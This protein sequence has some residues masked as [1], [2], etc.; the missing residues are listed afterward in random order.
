MHKYSEGFIY[1]LL[2]KQACLITSIAK[3]NLKI[4]LE[5]LIEYGNAFVLLDKSVVSCIWL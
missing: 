5:T 4:K 2:L 3:P 1:T